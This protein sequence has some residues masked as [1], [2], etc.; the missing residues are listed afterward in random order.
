MKTNAD[1]SEGRN[2]LL[3]CYFSLLVYQDDVLLCLQND[4]NFE[5]RDWTT[6]Q[7]E[8]LPT[9]SQLVRIGLLHG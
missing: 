6:V 9:G 4:F 3:S 5:M 2:L 1:Y 7:P 8:E